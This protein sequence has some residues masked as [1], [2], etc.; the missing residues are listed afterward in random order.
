VKARRRQLR[1]EGARPG[2][3]GLAA[4]PGMLIP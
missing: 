4:F 3:M 1:G 2:P